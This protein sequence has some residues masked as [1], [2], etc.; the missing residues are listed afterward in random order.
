[1]KIGNIGGVEIFFDGKRIQT[2]GERGQVET[3]IFPPSYHD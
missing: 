3:L 1:V 2:K